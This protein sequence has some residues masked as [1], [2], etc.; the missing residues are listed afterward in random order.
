M[1]N[2]EEKSDFIFWRKVSFYFLKKGYI[3]F[4]EE[5]LDFIF[6]KKFWLPWITSGTK[7]PQKHLPEIQWWQFPLQ[8]PFFLC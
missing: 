1:E 2:T 4:S 8:K 7:N 5:K 6:C 3:L